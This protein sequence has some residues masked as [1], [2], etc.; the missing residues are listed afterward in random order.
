MW[1]AAA[2][3]SR[4]TSPSAASTNPCSHRGHSCALRLRAV[5]PLPIPSLCLLH[6]ENAA[7]PWTGY[8]ERHLSHQVTP[9]E[10]KPLQH[11]LQCSKPRASPH[12]YPRT[13]Q[14][15]SQPAPAHTTSNFFRYW[16]AQGQ[17]SAL[18]RSDVATRLLPH[19]TDRS[20]SPWKAPDCPF[21][22]NRGSEAQN[23]PAPV[24]RPV[25]SF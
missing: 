14:G 10:Q 5:I 19:T 2:L 4:A 1:V 22:E 12:C 15:R 9:A 7:H 17:G 24:P 20:W 23:P 18:A 6:P 21:C 3:T 16:S 11:C 13:K 8:A 25:P